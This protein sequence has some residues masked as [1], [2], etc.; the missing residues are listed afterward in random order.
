MKLHS[1]LDIVTKRNTR[2]DVGA[3]YNHKIKYLVLT[4]VYS[5]FSQI[6]R[7]C[8]QTKCTHFLHAKVLEHEAVTTPV[9]WMELLTGV[10]H[11][12]LCQ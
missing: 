7:V 5:L 9:S 8:P 1:F 2:R 3:E 11:R 10:D 4:E 12:E 6:T